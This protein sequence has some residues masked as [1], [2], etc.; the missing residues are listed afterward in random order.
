MAES[1]KI[2]ISSRTIFRIVIILGAFGF[3][4][5]IRDVLLLIFSAMVVSSAIEPIADFLQKRRVPRA[6][7]VLGV[8]VVLLVGISIIVTLLIPPLTE[9]VVQLAEALPQLASTVQRWNIL[10]L[11]LDEQ[12][13]VAS[14]Q[15]LL[16]RFGEGL[17]GVSFNVVEQTRSLFS[18]IFSVLF[19]FVLA[20]YMVIENDSLVKL[21][22]I[23]TPRQ[24]F[25]YVEQ[26][27]QRIQHGL[28]RWV[29][30]QLA[31]GII[32]GLMVGV[33]LWLIGVKYALL[34][35]LLT[36]LLE[37]IPVIGPIVA[38][39]PA[40]LIAFSQSWIYAV[41]T[42]VFCIFV[43]QVENHF[44][45]PTIMRKAA[46]LNPLVT[47]IAILVGARLAGV[48]GAILSVPMAIILTV[49]WSDIFSTSSPEDTLRNTQQDYRNTDYKNL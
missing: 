36:G 23:I 46:G 44:F 37:I 28:G 17:T 8:Y 16:L 4:F 22:R 26:T 32:V 47:M 27:L 34:L 5:M 20:F 19:V 33:G 9:Q 13:A 35:G 38:A 12:T 45:V 25:P 10:G 43:Q 29:M 6:V 39:I 24:H 48:I 11:Q 7:T 30:A 49:F 2:D 15:N 31:L 14:L 1:Q 3:V 21:F 42:L 18:G 40:I 41:V